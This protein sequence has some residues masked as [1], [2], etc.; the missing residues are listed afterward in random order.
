MK[1]SLIK[2]ILLLVVTGSI[3]VYVMVTYLWFHHYHSFDFI[4]QHRSEQIAFVVGKNMMNNMTDEDTER[5]YELLRN[6]RYKHPSNPGTNA[7]PKRTLLCY[8]QNDNLLFKI[9][10]SSYG[11]VYVTIDDKEKE[12]YIHYD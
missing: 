12:Y 11:N 1:K 4:T 6:N 3:I 9:V 5:T 8:D 10:F 2:R 7:A